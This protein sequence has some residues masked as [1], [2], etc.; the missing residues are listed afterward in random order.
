MES[1]EVAVYVGDALKDP[2]DA[3]APAVSQR[4][5]ITHLPIVAAIAVG[6]PVLGGYLPV[7]ILR[8]VS[9]ADNLAEAALHHRVERLVGLSCKRV[10]TAV[11]T[12]AELLPHEE[13][14]LALVLLIETRYTP[15]GLYVD[16]LYG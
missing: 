5:L 7:V 4:R 9:P 2:L 14:A 3:V 16:T 10:S 15:A 8:T 1:G 11:K 13:V 12:V 6:G